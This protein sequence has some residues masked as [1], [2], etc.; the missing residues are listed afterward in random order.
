MGCRIARNTA[1][2]SLIG[3]SQGFVEKQASLKFPSERLLVDISNF[4]VYHSMMLSLVWMECS[5]SLHK[6][7]GSAPSIVGLTTLIGSTQS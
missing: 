4:T 5:V 6:H 3:R 7:P 2:V 1:A